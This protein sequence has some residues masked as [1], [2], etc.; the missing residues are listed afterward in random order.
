MSREILIIIPAKAT[1]SRFPGKNRRLIGPIIEKIINFNPLIVTD[2]FEIFEKY[3]KDVSVQVLHRPYNMTNA[4]DS[5]FSV[6]RWAYQSLNVDYDYIVTIFPN[7]VDF[8]IELLEESIDLLIEENL[9]DVRSYDE[10]G[11]ESGL[12]CM[13][14]EY[15]LT[16]PISVYCGAVFSRTREIHYQEELFNDAD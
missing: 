1:S 6:V 5:V 2:D 11:K 15:L 4:N 7:V 13:K 8:S 14:R 16:G 3:E 10:K 12:I 9:N